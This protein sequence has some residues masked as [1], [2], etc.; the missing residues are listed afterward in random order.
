VKSGSLRDGHRWSGMLRRTRPGCVDGTARDGR[1][2]R[3]VEL[4]QL[5][6]D[7]AGWR[8]KRGDEHQAIVVEDEV[9]GGVVET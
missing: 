4:C 1:S 8:C 2:Q 6:S 3:A 9:K 7:L 5:A